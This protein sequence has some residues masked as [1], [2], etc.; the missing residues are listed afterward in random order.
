MNALLKYLLSYCIISFG[1]GDGGPVDRG[2]TFEP[3]PEPAAEPEKAADPEPAAE[4]EKEEPAAEPE[5]EEPSRDEKGKFIPKAEFDNRLKRER[6]AR[7]SAE[8]RLA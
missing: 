7:E 1:D 3:A 2:D 6:E 4:P 5:K 8:R